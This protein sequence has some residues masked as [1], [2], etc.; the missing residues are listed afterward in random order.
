MFR[1]SI[2]VAAASLLFG[3]PAS[4]ADLSYAGE[5]PQLA[6]AARAHTVCDDDGYCYRTRAQRYVERWH[7]DDDDDADVYER[8][9]Y[10][11]R[12]VAPRPGFYRSYDDDE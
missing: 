7:D 11:P 9:D 10:R 4:A 6:P 3:L 8:R 12:Y 2:V 5:P 1:M